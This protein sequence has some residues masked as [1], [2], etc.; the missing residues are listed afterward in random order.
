MPA[1]GS[2]RSMRTILRETPFLA[3][4]QAEQ[5]LS[6]DALSLLAA[7]TLAFRRAGTG[8]NRGRGRLEADLLD[9]SQQSILWDYADRFAREVLQ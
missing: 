7:V 6:E 9:E 5:G 1:E 8:R 2:L 4:L 3:K